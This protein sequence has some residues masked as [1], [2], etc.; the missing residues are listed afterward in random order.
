MMNRRTFLGTV[1]AA[2]LL[3]RNLSFAA[4]SRRMT[5]IGMQA[6]TVRDQMKQNFAGTLAKVAQIGYKEIEFA[7]YYGHSPKEVRSIL[8]QNGLTSPS[9]HVDYKLLTDEWPQT[10]DAARIMG[11]TYI[12]C[13]WIPEEV[14]NQP[15]GW[16][17]AADTFNRAGEASKKSGIQFT[18]HNH[19]FEFKPVNGKVPYDML[20][21]ETDPSL[22]KMEMDLCWASVGGAD[23]V[24]YFN[25]YPGRF[26]EVHVKDVK[27][28]P[29]RGSAQS[30]AEPDSLGYLLT[31]VGSGVIDWKRIFAASEKG[32]IKHY[33][34][35]H[36]DP[37]DPFATL[38]NSFTYLQN[39]RF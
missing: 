33:F 7:G 16:K 2:T 27:Q 10:L 14:R 24:A 22:V 17:R 25:K 31:D 9:S 19:N 11:Q 28:L 4:D 5:N 26:P 30:W 29:P 37:K 18:Y 13:P 15:D 32:G 34:V 1:S 23:P 12:C 38:K 35:E 39:L 6:Y 3:S 8:D 36:D 21:A 20:L